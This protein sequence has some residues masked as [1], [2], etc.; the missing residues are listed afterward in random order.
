MSVNNNDS[1]SKKATRFSL[2]LGRSLIDISMRIFNVIFRQSIEFCLI[3]GFI[4]FE[5][6]WF[7]YNVS[8]SSSSLRTLKP[9]GKVNVVVLHIYIQCELFFVILTR[10]IKNEQKKMSFMR[11]KNF[12]FHL[13][14]W[15]VHLLVGGL[16]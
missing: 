11:E 10:S 16:P 4:R 9:I 15:F 5:F 7:V 6:F 8:S 13:F 1:S 2:S 3:H 14:L 12:F